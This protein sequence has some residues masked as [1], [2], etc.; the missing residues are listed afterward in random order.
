MVFGKAERRYFVMKATL[1]SAV[2]VLTVML[3]HTM[4]DGQFL[5]ESEL[6]GG[7]TQMELDMTGADMREKSKGEWRRLCCKDNQKVDGLGSHEAWIGVLRKVEWFP[8]Q[9]TGR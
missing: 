1:A 8:K 3:F 6:R 2:L 4:A 9:S 5:Y 7:G